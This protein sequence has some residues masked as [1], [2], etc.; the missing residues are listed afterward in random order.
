MA[1]ARSCS[2]VRREHDGVVVRSVSVVARLSRRGCQIWDGVGMEKVK[3]DEMWD[4][5]FKE[6]IV[7]GSA[8]R[9]VA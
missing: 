4:G 5:G 3:E 8:S 6:I 2:R 1:L 7:W 9:E